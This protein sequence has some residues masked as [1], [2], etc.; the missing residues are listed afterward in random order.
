MTARQPLVISA[1]IHLAA[2]IAVAGLL[3][4]YHPKQNVDIEVVAP[5]E[6]MPA[7][8]TQIRTQTAPEKPKPK[9]AQPRAV[10]GVSRKA[11]ESEAPDAVAAKQG[12]TV[13]KAPDNDKLRPED[14]DSLPVPADEYLV[15]RMPVLKNP[16]RIP[17][18]AE[19]RQKNIEGAVI[20]DI[21]VD[22]KGKV[23]EAKLVSGPGAGLNEAALAAVRGFEF[24]PALIDNKPVAVRIPRYAY[25]FV[26]DR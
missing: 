25:R 15:T 17:Y 13:A 6:K 12:N 19:A 20:M 9:V 18:P 7:Q 2:T 24:E 8:Q 10:F 14:A 3:W 1:G 22:D 4:G 21:L 5:P 16:V 11:V 26:L 23:R